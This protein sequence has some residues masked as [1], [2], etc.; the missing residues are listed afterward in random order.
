MLALILI[1]GAVV[2]V[3]LVNSGKKKGAAPA[4]YVPGQPGQPGQP[5]FNGQP[6]Q[7]AG[8]PYG[9]GAT[10]QPGYQQGSTGAGDDR[11]RPNNQG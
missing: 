7:A 10:G 4:G 11:F 9:Q 3:I 1:A 6:G 2:A 8:S 5:G